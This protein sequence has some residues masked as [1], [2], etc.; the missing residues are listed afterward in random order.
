MLGEDVLLAAFQPETRLDKT[1]FVCRIQNLLPA[2]PTS[3]GQLDDHVLVVGV[4]VEQE[5]IVHDRLTRVRRHVKRIA[6]ED[7]PEHLREVR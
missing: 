1:V 2:N 3:T 7:E 5:R 6:R 4:E